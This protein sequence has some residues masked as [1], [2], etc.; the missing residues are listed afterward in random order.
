[1]YFTTINSPLG[2]LTLTANQDGLTGVYFEEHRHFKGL[3]GGQRKSDFPLFDRVATQLGQFFDGTRQTFDVPLDLSA[4]TAFQ[5]QVWRALQTIPY[6]E[7]CSYGELAR[8]L[9]NPQAVRAVGAANGRNPLSIIIPCHR[10]IAANGALTGYAGGLK[11]K[12]YLLKFEAEQ[13]HS[14]CLS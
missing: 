7:T 12:H 13:H 4:G 1:M 9:H 14:F 3:E 8:H 10:V 6:G 11:N 5:Q 2:V